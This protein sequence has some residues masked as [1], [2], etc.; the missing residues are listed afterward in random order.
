MVVVPLT[1]LAWQEKYGP[2]RAGE[3]SSLPHGLTPEEEAFLRSG[4]YQFDTSRRTV[5]PPVPVRQIAEFERMQGV[6]IRYPLGISYALVRE[7]AEDATVYSIVSS[8]TVKNQALANYVAN[9]VNTGNCEFVIAP[10]DS[11]WTRDY[12]PW[13]VTSNGAQM[14]IVD[15]TYNRP[16]P[17]DNAIPGVCTTQ[18]GVSLYSMGIITAGGNYM[19]DGMG[20]SVS[21]DLIVEENP[22]MSESELRQTVSN[23]LGVQTYHI[24]PDVNGEYIKHIDCWAKFLDPGAIMIREVP[25]SHPQHDDVE[26]AVAYFSSQ[27]SSYGVP[28]SIYRVNTPNDEPYVNSLIL[29][30]KVLVPQDGTEWDDDALA[31]YRA[32]MPGYEVIGFTGSWYSTDALH[33]RARGIPDL[34]ML[35]V[36]HVPRHAAAQTGDPVEVT[37]SV[38]ACSGQALLPDDLKLF[39]SNDGGSN[40]N[41][42]ALVLMRADQYRGII[43]AQPSPCTMSYY[44]HAADASGRS[45][46]HPFMGRADP[47][48][49]AVTGIDYLADSDGDNLPDQWEEDYF[50]D[51]DEDDDDDSD[52]DTVFNDDEFTAGTDPD[53]A[54]NYPSLSIDV[55]GSNAVVSFETIAADELVY[56]GKTRVYTLQ[57]RPDLKTGT[58]TGVPG[59]EDIVGVDGTM[60]YAVPTNGSP[61]FFRLSIRLQDENRLFSGAGREE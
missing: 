60:E 32:A 24:V 44:L 46:N 41:A 48:T 2:Y 27:T 45:E 57:N 28:Y 56:W 38:T 25:R 58:W 15:F 9:S 52:G 5:P 61:K 50:E 39:W 23:Y 10:T 47:H 55:S 51:L 6:L 12:G 42:A 16:R 34:G 36:L 19:T 29:N 14:S 22:S 17:N 33:C 7:M 8:Q 11:H 18:F 3:Y 21:T 13:W 43:P 49:F 40:Y 35:S 37:A 59:Y 20:I 31:A 4:E 30:D 1:S 54:T 26:D 53:D